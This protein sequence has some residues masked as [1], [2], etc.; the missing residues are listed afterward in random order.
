MSL[1]EETWPNGQPPLDCEF[2]LGR[3]YGGKFKVQ[4]RRAAESM[5]EENGLLATDEAVEFEE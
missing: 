1:L 3:I 4:L 5:N 2:W